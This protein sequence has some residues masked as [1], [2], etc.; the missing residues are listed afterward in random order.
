M[1]LSFVLPAAIVYGLL[2][3]YVLIELDNLK[4]K[5]LYQRHY[6]NAAYVPILE[7]EW[8]VTPKSSISCGKKTSVQQVSQVY[9]C[10]PNRIRDGKY[11]WAVP[12]SYFKRSVISNMLTLSLP[13]SCFPFQLSPWSGYCCDGHLCHLVLVW[14][15]NGL[16]HF[17]V[18]Y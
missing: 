10:L 14:L 16:T 13:V 9:W 5:K 15:F 1:S 8:C 3:C 4:I 17:T 6:L 12:V 18:L 11:K 2:C 7:W